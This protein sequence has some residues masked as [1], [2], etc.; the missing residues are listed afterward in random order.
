MANYLSTDTQIVT[1]DELERLSLSGQILCLPDHD[2]TIYPVFQVNPITG[3]VPHVVSAAKARF[4]AES[5]LTLLSWW[6]TPRPSLQGVSFAEVLH[7]DMGPMHIEAALL[8]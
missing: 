4:Q 3:E 2:I 5:P 1:L 8:K 6:H 7:T